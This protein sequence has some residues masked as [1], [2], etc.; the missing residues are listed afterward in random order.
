MTRAGPAGIRGSLSLAVGE[1]LSVET[2]VV[3]DRATSSFQ[4][5]ELGLWAIERGR[6]VTPRW[7]R[8]SGPGLGA[9]LECVPG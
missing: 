9:G 4:E 3:A 6:G 2:R 5:W 8:V 7:V 1:L